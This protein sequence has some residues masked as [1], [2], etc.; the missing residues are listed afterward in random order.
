MGA[1]GKYD[2]DIFV[3]VGEDTVLALASKLGNY[4][5]DNPPPRGLTVIYGYHGKEN[6]G[7]FFKNFSTSELQTCA[8]LGSKYVTMNRVLVL[9]EGLTDREIQKYVRDGR[10]F[11]TWCYSANR[12]RTAMENAGTREQQL[13][14]G[15][16]VLVISKQ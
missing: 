5:A 11:F 12:V 2:R 15:Q 4:W 1:I 7:E 9:K 13:T 3:H 16:P 8:S 10:V 14:N 6:T